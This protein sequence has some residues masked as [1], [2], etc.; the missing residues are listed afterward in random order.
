MR[1]RARAS[2]PPPREPPAP[3]CSGTAGVWPFQRGHRARAVP[4]PRRGLAARRL[5]TCG[6]G[7]RRLQPACPQCPSSEP[8]EVGAQRRGRLGLGAGSVGTRGGGTCAHLAFRAEA[9]SPR[10]SGGF[11]ALRCCLRRGWGSRRTQTGPP[12][13]VSIQFTL[14][15]ITSSEISFQKRNTVC[16][17]KNPTTDVLF[18]D[19]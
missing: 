18:Q 4:R 12:L 13:I 19:S 3:V 16:V 14:R 6:L 2:A 8:G 15:N 1:L 5:L 11:R 17:D 9:A 10:R 7:P